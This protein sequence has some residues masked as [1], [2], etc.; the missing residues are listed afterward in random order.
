VLTL[1]SGTCSA[2]LI[3]ALK[4]SCINNLLRF[5]WT[6]AESLISSEK[7]REQDRLLENSLPH[8]N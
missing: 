7:K 4:F 3:L 8:R 2:L 5:A 6:A 1:A